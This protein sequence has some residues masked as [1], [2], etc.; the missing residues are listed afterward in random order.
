MTYRIYY[1]EYVGEGA[2][3]RPEGFVAKEEQFEVDL[4]QGAPPAAKD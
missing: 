1:N 2:A 3:R 4:V